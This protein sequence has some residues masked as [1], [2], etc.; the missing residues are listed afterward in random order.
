M[1]ISSFFLSLEFLVAY[2]SIIFIIF[3]FN[4]W[5]LHSKSK[6]LQ[7]R[8][9]NAIAKLRLIDGEDGFV[10]QFEQYHEYAGNQF[11][12]VWEE[13]VEML[14]LPPSGSGDPI[15]NTS[16]VSKYLN[17]A[18]IIFP[19]VDFRFYHS[20]PNL[21]MGLGILGTFTGLAVGV[22]S[23]DSGLSS[24]IPTEIT[25]SLEQLLSGASL[26]FIS[27][28]IGIVLSIIFI[29][30]ERAKSRTLHL[31]LGEW[32]I[33][34]EKRMRLIT[35]PAIAL[36]QLKE[37]ENTTQQ[38]ARFNTDLIFTF[39][40]A[41]ED[42]VA[43]RLAPY[44]EQVVNSIE[45]L[46]ADRIS[47]AGNMIESSLA[48][49]TAAMQ[50]KTGS[51]FDEMASIVSNLNE[52]LK[53]AS[54][55][56]SQT[57]Q[58]INASMDSLVKKI[59]ASLHETIASMTETLRQSMGGVSNIVAD[60]SK[61]MADQMVLSS[62]AAAEELRATI[63][64]LTQELAQTSVAA[65]SQISGSVHGLEE[66]ANSLSA[67]SKQNEKI[68][69]SMTN[70]VQQLNSLSGIISSSHKEMTVISEKLGRVAHDIQIS[71]DRSVDTLEQTKETVNIIRTLVQKLEEYQQSTTNS[72]I[73]Y[74]D[75]FEN[76]DESLKNVFQQIDEGLVAY[77][78][79]V[80]KFAT[81]LDKTSADVIRN[82]TG[83]IG[84]LNESIEELIPLLPNSVTE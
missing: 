74:Q 64:E 59:E 2:G 77:C 67:S 23:A 80:E 56:F 4:A 68:L 51:Q 19:K 29:W 33:E 75:R 38:L 58:D 24:G 9:R 36:K 12:R 14:I 10:E 35:V 32:V 15:Q 11:G 55:G 31:V 72:W 6:N 49:F 44:L 66:A 20:L 26:A 8:F 76:I 16:E 53:D 69:T 17:E 60:A 41:L 40:Q 3:A 22:G 45:G 47:E 21:L 52:T 73:E 79:Q 25:A 70:F 54:N 61:Q 43:G 46:R 18:T 7:T 27:S 57:N 63:S 30:I 81:T 65:V 1:N 62:N 71:S 83:A 84:G 50:Q 78:A 37:A 42:K 13:F 5:R 39:E 48:Q 34:L 82:L 28:I